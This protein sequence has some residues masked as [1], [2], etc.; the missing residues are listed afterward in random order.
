MIVIG[1]GLWTHAIG[2][3]EGLIISWVFLLVTILIAFL[4]WPVEVPALLGTSRSQDDAED[5]TEKGTDMVLL[6]SILN[7]QSINDE[8]I[9]NGTKPA[10]YVEKFA[11]LR[12]E[13]RLGA[14]I[15]T[16]RGY[17]GPHLV[18]ARDSAPFNVLLVSDLIR[19]GA[20]TYDPTLKWGNS[21]FEEVSKNV[22]SGQP[23]DDGM[24]STDIEDDNGE[25]EYACQTTLAPFLC[26]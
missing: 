17:A 24:N 15:G 18:T 10:E 2:I 25:N 19:N 14:V 16:P 1:L 11:T 22:L 23:H 9:N 21:V 3:G 4:A 6:S 20:I 5:V 8:V 13:S 26:S 7:G 12:D